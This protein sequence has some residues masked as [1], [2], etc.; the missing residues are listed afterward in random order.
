MKIKNINVRTRTH[1]SPLGN[2]THYFTS[3]DLSKDIIHWS[4]I[5]CDLIFRTK[6]RFIFPTSHK[7]DLL[8]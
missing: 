6:P 8:F 7:C 2:K 5:F 3:A 1:I 4:T